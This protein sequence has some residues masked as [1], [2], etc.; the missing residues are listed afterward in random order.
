MI[1][2]LKWILCMNEI[3]WDLS[4][5]HWGRVTQICVSKLIIGSDNGLSPGRSV[6]WPVPSHYLNQCWNT[7][8]W[9]LGNKQQ[10][11]LHQN[12]YLFIQ[13][14][15][16]ENVVWKMAAILSRPQCVKMSLVGIPC[17]LSYAVN[18]CVSRWN[19]RDTMDVINFFISRRG[20]LTH[21]KV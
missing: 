18:W 15:A 13:E 11:N 10:W 1:R 6:A 5:T 17:I 9:T 19:G 8:N 4:L 16:F 14:N 12:S 2:P 7:V 3:K 21:E 20:G